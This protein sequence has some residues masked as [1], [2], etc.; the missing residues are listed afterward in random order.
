VRERNIEFNV[1][2]EE[3]CAEYIHCRW[4]DGAVFG[5]EYAPV[6]LSTR[7]YFHPSTT[8]QEFLSAGTWDATF[9]FTDDEA[10]VS[11]ATINHVSGGITVSVTA[12]DDVGVAGIEYKIDGGSYQRYDNPVFVATG[13][14][15]EYRAVDVNGNNE[16]SSSITASTESTATPTTPQA[17]G[18][19]ALLPG[20]DAIGAL[21]P[22]ES[23]VDGVLAYALLF[24]AVLALSATLASLYIIQ[25]S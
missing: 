19:I 13:S 10:P 17:V 21:S 14:T 4:D 16:A 11:T 18:G 9:D 6:H 15:I 7:D 23:R 24:A 22:A 1:Q 5:A 3:V 2:L 25:R 20:D 12:T 8:G